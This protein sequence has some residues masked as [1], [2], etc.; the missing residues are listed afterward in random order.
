MQK[1]LPNH[2][3][4]SSHAEKRYYNYEKPRRTRCVLPGLFIS[5]QADYRSHER[6]N[7]TRPIS[8]CVTRKKRSQSYPINQNKAHTGN[9]SQCVSVKKYLLTKYREV[10]C[11]VE[12]VDNTQEI[13]VG[14]IFIQPLLFSLLNSI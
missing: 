12:L 11:S 7:L 5:C 4:L 14:N 13:L 3:I 8:P 1:H 6:Q 2:L 9:L 10:F